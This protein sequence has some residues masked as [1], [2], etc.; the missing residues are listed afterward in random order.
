[1]EGIIHA[2][3]NN[4]NFVCLFMRNGVVKDQWVKLK[5]SQ[6]LIG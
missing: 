4:W 2:S 1:M 3:Q 6:I 5:K